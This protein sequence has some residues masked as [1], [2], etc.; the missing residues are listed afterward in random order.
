MKSKKTIAVLMAACLCLMNISCAAPDTGDNT[1]GQS[2]EP[3]GTRTFVDSAGREV[4]VPET[5]TRIIPSGDMAQM[6][7]WPLAADELVSVAT[8]V[9]EAQEKYL[10]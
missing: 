5:I 4:E 2:Q 10:L 6:F 7:L 9:T 3:A 8:P 1:S